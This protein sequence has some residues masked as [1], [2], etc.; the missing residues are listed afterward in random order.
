MLLA[1]ECCDLTAY[2]SE[3]E[4]VKPTA[5]FAIRPLSQYTI[6][7]ASSIM[8]G[9]HSQ[10]VRL[11]S[12][13]K[14]A[15]LDVSQERDGVMDVSGHK[16]FRSV[17]ATH[18]VCEGDWYF[19]VQILRLTTEDTDGAVRVGWSTRRSNVEGPVGHDRHGFGLR[20]RGGEFV[21]NGHLQ[22]YGERLRA[23]DVIGCRLCLP[24]TIPKAQRKKLQQEDTQWMEYNHIYG[25]ECVAPTVDIAVVQNAELYFLKNGYDFGIP[26]LLIQENDGETAGFN[27]VPAGIYYPT[28][29]VFKAGQVR[30]NFGPHFSNSVPQGSTPFCDCASQA[31]NMV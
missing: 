17:R 5:V 24:S 10:H 25:R 11:S 20:D 16:G 13:D 28:V 27:G 9:L 12:V 8:Q 30:V 7:N 15:D 22:E 18:G 2:R 29:S 3:S 1:C 21:H 6:L 31:V 19:E 14:A 23:G 26:R 4:A